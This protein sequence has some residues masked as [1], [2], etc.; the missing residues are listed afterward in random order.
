[1]VGAQNQTL[2]LV[3][4]EKTAAEKDSSKPKRNKQQSKKFT[5]TP[6][7]VFRGHQRSVESVAVNGDG[8]FKINIYKKLLQKF[9]LKKQ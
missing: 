1:L 9:D 3:A 6:K 5:F 8:F 7:A 2:I 4:I